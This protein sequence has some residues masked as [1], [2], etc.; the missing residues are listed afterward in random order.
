MISERRVCKYLEL[1]RKTIQNWRFGAAVDKRKG[2][3]RYVAHRLTK[4]EQQ[5]FYDVAN[6]KRFADCTPEQIIARL[7][8]EGIYYGS[9][10]TL[11]RILRKHNALHHRVDTKKPAK[12]SG[13]LPL[14][15]T[16]PNQVWTWGITW[17]KTDIV[18]LFKCGYNIIDLYDRNRLINPNFQFIQ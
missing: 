8:E 11:Y 10:S 17:L 6:S 14:Q 2:N 5:T 7:A 4:E 1:N 12:N 9:T 16:G 15:V 3:S 18:G 13:A